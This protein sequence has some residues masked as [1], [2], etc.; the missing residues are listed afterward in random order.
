M[1][2]WLTFH[3]HHHHHDVVLS[4]RISL[5]LSHHSSLSFIASDRSSWLHPVFSQKCCMY[6]RA[7]RPAFDRPYVGVH[8][9]LFVYNSIIDWVQNK[10]NQSNNNPLTGKI[11]FIF[12]F[13]CTSILAGYLMPNP[14]YTYIL[15]VYDLVWLGFIAYQP[16]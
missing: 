4:A 8:V 5:T 14:V 10:V 3:H 2:L 9:Q 1:P 12:G 13:N 7:G 11:V 15:N 6:V 16:S